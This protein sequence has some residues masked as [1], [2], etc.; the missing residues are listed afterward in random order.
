MLWI[1]TAKHAI[2][3]R[4]FTSGTLEATTEYLKASGGRAYLGRIGCEVTPKPDSG[5]K[6]FIL[7]HPK[8]FEVLYEKN[9][10]IVNLTETSSLVR[11]EDKENEI[12]LSGSD[13]SMK[14]VHVAEKGEDLIRIKQTLDESIDASRDRS[15]G[16]RV[17]FGAVDSELN[18]RYRLMNPVEIHVFVGLT[19][20]IFKS[21]VLGVA[22]VLHTLEPF[23][24]SHSVIKIVEDAP[25]VRLALNLLMIDMENFVDVELLGEVL[26]SE[27]FLPLEDILS[28]LLLTREVSDASQIQDKRQLLHSILQEEL[29]DLK[30]KEA[31]VKASSQRE[32]GSRSNAICFDPNDG[33]AMKSLALTNAAVFSESVI[34]AHNDIDSAL[35][36]LPTSL[37]RALLETAP[38]L[39]EITEI[40][41]DLGR[42]PYFRVGKRRTF[43]PD[44]PS[45]VLSVENIE[46]IVKPLEFG[47]DNRASLPMQLHRFSAI[48]NRKD[49][50]VGLTIRIGR[51]VEGSADVLL[52]YI[53]GDRNASIL[54]LGPPG[55]G[56]T[57]VIREITKR[58][59]EGSNVVVVDT[60]N[61]IGGEGEVPHSSIGNARRMMIKSVDHQGSK[62]IECVQNHTPDVMVVDEIG[63]RKEVEAARKVVQRGVRLIAS[64]H[65]DLKSLMEEPELV[66]LVGDIKQV[67]IGDE[68][69]LHEA[70]SRHPKQKLMEGSL[71]IKKLKDQRVRMPT[72]DVVVELL[73]GSPDEMRVITDV[74][75]AADSILE[76]VPFL[77][78]VRRRE[79]VDS[80]TTGNLM[81]EWIMVD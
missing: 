59:A 16:L 58:L 42:Q 10:I 79:N 38:S 9:G 31:V 56:K 32:T 44:N 7:D 1:R 73:P 22:T 80:G 39:D 8:V 35:N 24:K 62:M 75:K 52:D 11:A 46:E 5:W 68:L 51:H 14:Q 60:S 20:F 21:A 53:M 48:R 13:I 45:F 26:V 69:A 55:S 71:R 66:G 27:P 61:E 54:V 41:L 23:L 28:R 81:M 76:R 70:S 18:Y 12:G 47:S 29:A 3:Y 40:G 67:A 78:Q 2:S 64:A 63:R 57:T 37:H 49:Q 30:L 50:I 4:R 33:Y 25:T 43:F 65:G 15:L 72:F 17:D 77:A 19:Q 36:T 74:P 6:E 34:V